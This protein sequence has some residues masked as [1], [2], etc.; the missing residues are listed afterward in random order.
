MNLEWP[1]SRSVHTLEIGKVLRAINSIDFTTTPMSVLN[2]H[3]LIDELHLQKEVFQKWIS[4]FV[5]LTDFPHFYATNGITD[6]IHH[7]L[8]FENRPIQRLRGDYVWPNIIKPEI[9][10]KKSVSEIDKNKVLYISN[11]ASEDGF[12]RK[13]WNEI[14]SSRA[15]IVLD[16]AYLG[17]V[18]KH[19]IPLAK[20]VESLFF[21]FSKGF[22]LSRLRVGWLF[23]RKPIPS[24]ETLHDVAYFPMMV[25]IVTNIICSRFQPD[26]VY[27]H[28]LPL[29]NQLC[30]HLDIDSSDSYLIGTCSGLRKP[31]LVR[32]DG[33][34]ARV[35]LAGFYNQM[36]GQRG[37]E[38]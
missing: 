10:V 9:D 16:C 20:N 32:E 37:F 31:D 35:P 13:D 36:N 5:D 24:L 22:G 23:S 7:W 6:A 18:R 25:P 12:F 26:T 28:M 11:P 1:S 17:S 3:Q 33:D 30:S 8:L 2:K 19:R 14:I 27:Q 29:Q 4:D 21:S 38:F 34:I 15:P